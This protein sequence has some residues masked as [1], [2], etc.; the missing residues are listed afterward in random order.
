MVPIEL[1]A[2]QKQS[3]SE[4]SGPLWSCVSENQNGSVQPLPCR[5]RP[6]AQRRR[7]SRQQR[8]VLSSVA[9]PGVAHGAAAGCGG[10]AAGK[11]RGICDPTAVRIPKGTAERCYGITLSWEKPAESFFVFFFFPSVCFN[12]NSAVLKKR[13]APPSAA[14]TE[15]PE[16]DRDRAPPRGPELPCA[17]AAD[18][19]YSFLFLMHLMVQKC[20]EYSHNSYSCRL[21]LVRTLHCQ[22]CSL[23]VAGAWSARRK[24]TANWSTTWMDGTSDILPFSSSPQSLNSRCFL[25]WQFSKTMFCE[26]WRWK[27]SSY[28]IIESW[29][30]VGWQRPYST[31]TPSPYVAQ[32]PPTAGSWHRARWPGTQEMSLLKLSFFKVEKISHGFPQAHTWRIHGKDQKSSFKTRRSSAA[33]FYEACFQ[34]CSPRRTERSNVQSKKTGR[35]QQVA[36]WDEHCGAPGGAAGRCC[37]ERCCVHRAAAELRLRCVPTAPVW[38]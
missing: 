8:G 31:P 18:A 23:K 28:I 35:R 32:S 17:S 34:L 29:Q 25:F 33:V 20:W 11:Q 19:P 26:I 24:W 6:F 13:R 36:P 10:G 7:R 30:G 27:I 3:L 9:A 15:E 14:R 12:W 1:A 21:L 5:P 22:H 2:V 16:L 4:V 38:R 37:W